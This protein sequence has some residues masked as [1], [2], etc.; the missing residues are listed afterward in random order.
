MVTTISA[1][2]PQ[3]DLKVEWPSALFETL[4]A[5]DVRHMFPMRG[6]RR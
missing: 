2:N 5:A 6:T 4:T 3:R 1:T